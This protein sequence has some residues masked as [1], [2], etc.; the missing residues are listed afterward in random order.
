M[1]VLVTIGYH[2]FK[3]V[4]KAC[5]LKIFNTMP[6]NFSLERNKGALNA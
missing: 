6:K 2:A 3:N 5:N 4:S 1:N